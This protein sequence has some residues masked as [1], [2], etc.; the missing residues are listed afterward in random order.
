MSRE[1]IDKFI[2]VYSKFYFTKNTITDEVVE[3][4]GI[5]KNLNQTPEEL[6]NHIISKLN[7]GI[8]D[9]EA[10]AWKA[11]KATW[12]NGGFKFD[13]HLLKTWVN[14]NGGKIK[15]TKDNTAFNKEQFIDFLNHNKIDITEY[16]F[17]DK[18]IRRQ[19]F[20]KIKDTYNLYNYGSV[21]IINQMFFLS[22][23]AIPLY[24]YY[25]HLG[26]KALFMNKSPL[27]IY[28]SDAPG[29]DDHPKGNNKKKKDY[30]NAVNILEEYMWLLKEVFPKEIHKNESIKYISRELDQ[31]LWVYGHAT[32]NYLN[33]K[34][35]I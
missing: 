28:I 6:E 10:F 23:G 16:D 21:N 34:R 12:E 29:K 30:Y 27:E 7:K 32:I 3:I 17:E 9:A 18:E 31:A 14:G 2:Q 8:Y 4:Y 26:V 19:L 24:D 25:A 20:I 15:L 1:E 22:K 13:K 33:I 11:G 5:P 35:S